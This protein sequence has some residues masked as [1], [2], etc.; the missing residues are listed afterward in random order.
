MDAVTT[1]QELR[2]RIALRES[3]VQDF[4]RRIRRFEQDLAKGEWAYEYLLGHRNNAGRRWDYVPAM[5]AISPSTCEEMREY[6]VEI[7]QNTATI[8]EHL[9]EDREELA[10]LTR[11]PRSQSFWRWLVNAA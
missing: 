4:T 1:E 6:I 9:E 7:R 2:D 3:Q 5:G 8:A 11:P 10:R